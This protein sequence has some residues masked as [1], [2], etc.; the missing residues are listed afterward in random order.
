M[1]LIISSSTYE[2]DV[3]WEPFGGLFSASIAAYLLKRK[4][5]AAEIDEFI[6]QMGVSRFEAL[7]KNQKEQLFT[8]SNKEILG[9]YAE[10]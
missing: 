9:Q 3:V 6:F 5:Y 4:V 10:N 7:E 2:N 8:I 1:E